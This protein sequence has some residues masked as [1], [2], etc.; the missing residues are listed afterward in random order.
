VH[1]TEANPPVQR[2]SATKRFLV[3]GSQWCRRS[4][5]DLFVRQK[6]VEDECLGIDPQPYLRAHPLTPPRILD[7]SMWAHHSHCLCVLK[8]QPRRTRRWRTTA[9][10][11]VIWC[12]HSHLAG[13]CASPA[14]LA[15]CGVC[16]AVFFGRDR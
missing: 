13:G 2:M 9:S 3:G 14:T 1:K 15:E 16:L 4:F 5:A 6:M 10:R 11:W 8:Q 7:F 12:I